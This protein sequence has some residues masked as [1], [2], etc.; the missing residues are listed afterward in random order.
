MPESMAL[1]P[2][3]KVGPLC[4]KVLCRKLL[5]PKIQTTLNQKCWVKLHLYWIQAD[6]DNTVMT[7]FIVFIAIR[8]FKTSRDDLKDMGICGL[9]VT[10]SQIPISFYIRV[11]LYTEGFSKGSL[12]AKS[13]RSLRSFVF[14]ELGCDNHH[15]VKLSFTED[16]N[17]L[18]HLYYRKTA[19]QSRCWRKCYTPFKG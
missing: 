17:M 11:F 10:T 15:W 3:Y 9:F 18:G 7:T 2:L 12:G 5:H 19:L 14:P 6:S 8:Y 13:C 16:K 4:P 1:S